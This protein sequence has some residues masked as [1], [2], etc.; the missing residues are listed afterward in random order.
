MDKRE[1]A[2][3]KIGLSDKEIKVYLAALKLG[4]TT[5]Y[6]LSKETGIARTTTY[7]VISDLSFK[8]LVE[9]QQSDGFTKKQTRI[10]AKNP[11]VIRK[12]LKQKRD[13]LHEAE[14]EIVD[15]LPSLKKDFHGKKSSSE[16]RYF[17]GIKGARKVFVGDYSDKNSLQ[18]IRAITKVLPMD[19]IGREEVNKDMVD[20]YYKRRAKDG[21]KI[22]E[23]F[24]LNDWTKHVTSYQYEVNKKYLDVFDFRYIDDPVFEIMLRLSVSG[25]KVWMVCEEGEEIWGAIINSK[26]LS[27]TFKSIFELIWKRAKKVTPEVV[28]SWG[29]SEFYKAQKRLEKK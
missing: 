21:A 27:M 17:P 5:P 7:D 1:E 24:Q 23:I 10:K 25:N 13:E 11:S 15:I 20:A 4:N 29:K 28:E 19:I 2:L 18:P 6:E 12:M 9:L 22:K 14:V 16:F 8:K 26:A 3:K